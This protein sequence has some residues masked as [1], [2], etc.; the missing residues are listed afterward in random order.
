MIFLI[1]TVRKFVI[2]T[3]GSLILFMVIFLYVTLYNFLVIII[4]SDLIYMLRTVPQLELL[5][6]LYCLA[7]C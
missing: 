1:S 6:I 3:Y 2:Y 4:F 7:L 5:S